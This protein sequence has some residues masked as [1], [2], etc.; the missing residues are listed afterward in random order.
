MLP[1]VVSVSHLKLLSHVT[2][3]KITLSLLEYHSPLLSSLYS[4]VGFPGYQQQHILRHLRDPLEQS[5]AC[6]RQHRC[7]GSC[8]KLQWAVH[9]MFTRSSGPWRYPAADPLGHPQYHLFHTTDTDIDIDKSLIVDAALR[10]DSNG[11]AAKARTS[12]M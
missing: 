3:E 12:I 2:Q 8:P 1:L 9:L 7:C 4:L 11:S 5:L 10:I 6:K